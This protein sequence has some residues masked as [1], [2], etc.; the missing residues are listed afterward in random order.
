M[1]ALA[2][3]GVHL[4]DHRPGEHRAACPRCRK[5]GRDDALAVR[6]EADGGG[7]W[8]C[9]RCGWA[10]GCR[11]ETATGRPV[12]RE[13]QRTAETIKP[14]VEAKARRIL[15]EAANAD[16]AHPYLAHKGIQPH[17][18]RQAGDRL[19][20]PLIRDARLWGLQF[21]GPDG[22]KVYL[23]GSRP[24]TAYWYIG[25]PVI[26]APGGR[27]VIAEGF[28][29]A[30]SIYEA[31]G[32]ASIIAFSA[33]NLQPVATH[34]RRV[35]PKAAIIIAPD[36]DDA[37]RRHAVEAARAANGRLMPLPTIGGHDGR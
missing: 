19:V 12:R 16:P 13:R 21:I 34:W 22:S 8:L 7:T 2:A 15:C 26:A 10:G 33:G 18:V 23:R 31:I 6:L 32:V 29:T 24:Q 11:G 9:H 1:Q 20:L 35:L 14:D 28:A 37:G 5:G 25:D 27:I 17:E 4:R 3:E 36:D 30:A